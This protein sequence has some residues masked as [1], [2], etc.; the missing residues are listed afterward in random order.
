M[1][2]PKISRRKVLACS[3]AVMAMQ[4][5]GCVT[6]TEAPYFDPRQLQRSTRAL[7]SMDPSQS[8]RTLPTT[9]EDPLGGPGDL[10]AGTVHPP[11]PTV[12]PTTGPA[13]AEG[14]E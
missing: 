9:Q 14:T 7:S 8:L 10:E 12:G 2:K 5:A 1:A 11:D 4:I 6:A 13:L 3:A